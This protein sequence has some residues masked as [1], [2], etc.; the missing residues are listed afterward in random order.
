MCLIK[1]RRR[2]TSFEV[3]PEFTPITNGLAALLPGQSDALLG[4][5][6]ATGCVRAFR[7]AE[8][9]RHELVHA[10]VREQQVRRI[11]QK[12]RGRH[13]GVLLRLEE[14]EER[15]ADLRTRHH[16]QNQRLV[17]TRSTASLNR[18]RSE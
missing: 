7:L 6:G 2:T 13:N 9:D 11:G 14:V 10:G 15:L 18:L 4:V 16:V 1:L 8:E 17:G 5:G 12:A 3:V